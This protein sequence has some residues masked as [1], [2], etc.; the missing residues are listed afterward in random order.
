MYPTDTGNILLY[1]VTTIGAR[2][3]HKKMGFTLVELLVVLSIIAVMMAAAIVSYSS[4]TK[5]S[6]DSKRKS[7]M[8]QVRQALEMYRADNLTYPSCGVGMQN[9][10]CLAGVTGFSTYLST[11]PT[12]PKASVTGFTYYYERPSETTY[13]LTMLSESESVAKTGSGCNTLMPQSVTGTVLY[14]FTNP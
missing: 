11:T 13:C 10:S 14:Q 2:M 3:K 1:T 9:V 4:V 6:R 7:D 5:K 12:D 8:E